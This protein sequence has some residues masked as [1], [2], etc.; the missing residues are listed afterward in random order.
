MKSVIAF[1]PDL[2]ILG[3]DPP[4]LDY[5]A[6]LSEI[7]ASKRKYAISADQTLP[8]RCVLPSHS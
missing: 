7:K 4:Q 8:F 1:E 2:V 5:C 6:L 3:A